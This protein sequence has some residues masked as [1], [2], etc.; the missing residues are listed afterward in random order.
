MN[1]FP[2]ARK[3]K[4]CGKEIFPSAYWV[5][6]EDNKYYCSWKCYN[7]RDDDKP[8][9]E[10][11]SPKV[12]DKIRILYMSGITS[13]EGK[14]GVVKSIDYLG[15]LH[16]TWGKLVVVPSEDEIEIIGENE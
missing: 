15:Q 4:K 8:K 7:H 6:K 16:G 10:I 13:Y 5:Y 9:R 11:V 2:G 14:T 12:G 1:D 3:C